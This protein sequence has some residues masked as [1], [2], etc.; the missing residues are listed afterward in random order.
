M[1]ILGLVEHYSHDYEIRPQSLL[2]EHRVFVIFIRGSCEISSEK[3]QYQP[4]VSNGNGVTASVA[5]DVLS[6]LPPKVSRTS[7]MCLIF[8]S[9][10]LFTSYINYF[11]WIRDDV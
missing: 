6:E 1:I 9:Q 7:S 4:I 5:E 3:F 8:W 11:P 2:I 10:P